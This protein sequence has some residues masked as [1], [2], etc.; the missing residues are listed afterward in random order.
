MVNNWKARIHTILSHPDKRITLAFYLSSL[1][2]ILWVPIFFLPLTPQDVEICGL[3]VSM[4]QEEL[5]FQFEMSGE[6]ESSESP[7]TSSQKSQ[8]ILQDSPES[9]ENKGTS[10]D[11]RKV[12]SKYT[13]E[14]WKDLIQ[15]LESTKDM[16]KNFLESYDNIVDNGLVSPEYIKRIRHY[17]DM[18]VKDVLPTLSTVDKDFKE[19]V[20]KSEEVLENHNLRNQ[21]IEEF[22]SSQEADLMV[23]ELSQD[24]K[25]E[26]HSTRYPP[27]KMNEAERDQ[28]LDSILK[29]SKE[30]QFQEFIETYSN[31]D[32]DKGDL[33][34]VFRDL[35][36]K[37]LQRLAY[38]FSQDPTYFTAD[39]FEENLNKE[40]YLRN[41]MALISNWKNSKTSIE[42]LF[43]I[44]D[45]YEIQER[46]LFQYY[47][48]IEYQKTLSGEDKKQIRNEMIRQ[49][50]D[51]Y[52]KLLN[53]KNI[54]S[55][56]QISEMYHK[57]RVSIGDFLLSTTPEGY[58]KK[59]IRFE[60]GRTFWEQGIKKNNASYL[61]LGIKEWKKISAEKNSGDF[62][63]SD[64]Y[65]R[66][67]PLLDNYNEN[68]SDISSI[69]SNRMNN[70]LDQKRNREER[71]LYPR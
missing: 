5:S 34:L 15:S 71:L 7:G 37:N 16:R 63:N 30:S 35:Y 26:N 49:V 39:Y 23:L 36:Y 31:Y 48:N 46:A 27:L 70:R 41:S 44:L 14:K 51:K 9:E 29:N 12:S 64:A 25:K 58:R 18:V 8:S 55:Y 10:E 13:N 20:F 4:E 1:F 22:R 56:E 47:Q 3:E 69:L 60:R 24:S 61:G 52:S 67:K 66:I 62:L 33:P 21:I 57:K 68:R 6:G 54:N 11:S 53:E 38:T 32:K 43:T 50:I 40:D 42:I 17:E 28:Y 45:I 65:D 2:H 59:D 19:D